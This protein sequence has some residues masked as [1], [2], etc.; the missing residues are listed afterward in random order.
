M[1][2]IG[3]HNSVGS[4][5]KWDQISYLACWMKACKCARHITAIALSWLQHFELKSSENESLGN[6]HVLCA[7]TTIKT[8]SYYQQYSLILFQTFCFNRWIQIHM[9]KLHAKLN[10]LIMN[11]NAHVRIWMLKKTLPGTVTNLN[12]LDGYFNLNDVNAKFLDRSANFMAQIYFANLNDSLIKLND[13]SAKLT[14]K[15]YIR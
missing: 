6:K 2:W 8:Y 5:V 1:P 10:E 11:L 12:A 7:L 15:T 13:K 4:K 9:H 3:L 14:G